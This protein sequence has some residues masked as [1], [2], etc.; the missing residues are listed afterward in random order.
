ME[1]NPEAAGFQM[2]GAYSGA[3]QRDVLHFNG[4]VRFHSPSQIVPQPV[5]STSGV[6]LDSELHM[7]KSCKRS[8]DS[9][10]GLPLIGDLPFYYWLP[11]EGETD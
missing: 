10:E 7:L 3:L 6:M 5:A 4:G 9:L 8:R 1:A 2:H 11:T